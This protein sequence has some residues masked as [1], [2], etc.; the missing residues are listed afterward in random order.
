MRKGLV[1]GLTLVFLLA[2]AAVAVGAYDHARRDMIAPGVRVAGVPVGGLHAAAARARV[3]AAL[4]APLSRPVVVHAG[5][6]TFR[7]PAARARERVDVDGLIARAV[8]LSRRGSVI[9]RTVHDL[10]GARV[11]TDLAARAT[12]SQPAVER[13]VRRVSA[14]VDRP[15]RDASVQ[16]SA[17]GLQI[18]HS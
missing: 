14:A 18:Q 13:L 4:R 6:R 8:A 11:D 9:T 5:G 1:I 7:L 3:D 12:F 17:A 15:A 2:G 16:P 10:T